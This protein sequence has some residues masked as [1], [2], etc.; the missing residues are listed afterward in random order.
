MTTETSFEPAFAP[1][2][3][4]PARPLR[5]GLVRDGA[6]ALL[7]LAAIAL[8]VVATVWLEGRNRLLGDGT[9]GQGVLM[10]GAGA[11]VLWLALRV[12]RHALPA[13]LPPTV[14]LTPTGWNAP[15]TVLGLGLIGVVTVL[16]TPITERAPQL[17][18]GEHLQFALLFAGLLLFAGGLSNVRRL[19]RPRIV[20]RDVLV[21]TPIL[22]LALFL[23]TYGLDTM[24][25]GSIDEMHFSDAVQRFIYN[26]VQLL[27]TTS[28]YLPPS[29]LYS[30][31]NAGTVEVFGRNFV[32]LRIVNGYI[33]VFTV[34]AVYGLAYAAADRK[35]ALLA[36]LILA[37]FPPHI[38]FS[39]I[40]MGQV[41][42]AL[43]GTMFIMFGARALRWNRRADWVWCG[44]SLAL[45]QYFYE[46]GRLIF[47]PLAIV[48]VVLLFVFTRFGSLR[49]RWKLIAPGLLIALIST[50]LIAAPVYIS[51]AANGQPFSARFNESRVGSDFF[52]NRF[53]NGLEEYEL[54]DI[55]LRVTDPFLIYT[56]LRD[57][58]G[59]FYAGEDPMIL[60]IF[61][62]IFLLGVAH[63]LWRPR[64]GLF[65]LIPLVLGASAG[66]ILIANGMMYHRY[67]MIMPALAVIV[68]VGV[69][70]T[71]P[72]LVPFA[73]PAVRPLMTRLK[74]GPAE[75][76]PE[77]TPESTADEQAERAPAARPRRAWA[78]GTAALVVSGLIIGGV[79]S[80]F[81]YGPFMHDFN[82]S[83]R[84]AKPYRDGADAV[85]RSRFDNPD[86][87][88]T[89]I[90][91]I[92]RVEPDRNV[93]QL[94]YEFFG[95]SLHPIDQRTT[96]NVDD[97]FFASLPRDRSYDFFLDPGD[98]E[99]FEE[100][101]RHFVVEPA[102][103]TTAN[104]PADKA[105]VLF[106][107]PLALNGGAPPADSGL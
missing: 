8:M 64:S 46:G 23:R 82:I 103:Y 93:P 27:N 10:F 95:A 104:I 97:A 9:L 69:R 102:R 62:P 40:A 74:G 73:F 92:S 101:T 45:T 53:E 6:G 17:V 44:I 65:V 57:G 107:A 99:T 78:L 26:D 7:T 18:L 76:A 86:W 43:F 85:L 11:V 91:L 39:R 106:R 52:S 1:T 58:T 30:Y 66:N 80:T 71:W 42:D 96:E 34:L 83:F 61:V 2:P 59:E 48:W 22:L 98:Q 68:A 75:G 70:Y 24:V 90:W 25:R 81:Y 84:A 31:W 36:A 5:A 21:L 54:R 3:T 13:L 94:L 16:S 35:T 28:N 56:S 33:G 67:I 50:V 47:P 12:S 4:A 32:G 100:L 63:A 88:N 15:M 51:M 55:I 49:G 41:G 37:T 89:Q 60:R 38:H 29:M 72:M 79:Q 77:S 19:S 20:W 87:Q 105:Y 14:A